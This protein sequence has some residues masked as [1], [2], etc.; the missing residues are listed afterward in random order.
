MTHSTGR[1]CWRQDWLAFTQD[2]DVGANGHTG[3]GC[4]CGN[5]SARLVDVLDDELHRVR[6]WDCGNVKDQRDCFAGIRL[7]IDRAG[8]RRRL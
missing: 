5:D 8:L 1:R 7:R 2:H 6:A 4:K 3:G